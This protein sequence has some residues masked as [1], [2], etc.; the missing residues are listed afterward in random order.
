[1][2]LEGIIVGVRDSVKLQ[3]QDEMIKNN[4]FKVFNY[5]SYKKGLKSIKMMLEEKFY[6]IYGRKC[7]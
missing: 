6:T 5:R 2:I 1:M 7:I 4:I 3:M